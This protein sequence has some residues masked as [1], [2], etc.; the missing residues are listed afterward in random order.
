[1]DQPINELIDRAYSRSYTAQIMLT[2]LEN[3]AIRNW[4]KSIQKELRISMIDC[5]VIQGKI[6][7]RDKLYI[8]PDVELQ[9]QII[10]QAH[11]TGP[12]GHPSH[13][14]TLDLIT[15]TYWWPRMSRLIE[16]F[17]QACDLCVRTKASRSAPQGFLQPLPVPFRAWSDISIDYVT[18]LPKCKRSGH[19]YEH[20]LVVCHLTKMRH[21]IP[22]V[23]LSAEELVSVFIGRVY[24]LHGAPDNIVSDR[25]TQFILQFWEQLSQR[26]G[27]RLR[28]SSSFH[29][30]TNRQT[31]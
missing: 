26:L 24:T 9:T 31:E 18:P 12:A 16:E 6:Y 22:V 11:S 14:K 30:A 8:P 29:P 5:K 17:V 28:P 3:P 23:S 2:V 7:Y 1:M 13:I 19:V 10:Y 4:P 20:L 27:V 15:R 25:G 21:L